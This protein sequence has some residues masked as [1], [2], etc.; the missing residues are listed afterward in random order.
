ME[1]LRFK[2]KYAPVILSWVKTEAD[3]VQWAGHALVWPITQKQFRAHLRES[4]GQPPSLYPFALLNRGRVAGYCELSN[5]QRHSGSAMLSRVIVAPR[6]RGKGYA[7]FMV[8]EVLRIGFADLELNRVWLGVF[9]FNEAAIECYRR[10]GFVHEGTLR[11]SAKVGESYWNC[12]LMSIL[13]KE[14]T[15]GPGVTLAQ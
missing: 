11:Q 10:A 6:R 2:M 13:R 3:T 5:H 14:W 1:I 9:D 4:Q 8:R 12:H 15:N 7:T